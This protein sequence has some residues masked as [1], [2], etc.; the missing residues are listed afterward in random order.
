VI[1]RLN[2]VPHAE[3]RLLHQILGYTRVF[4]DAEDEGVRQS[5]V[6]VVEIADRVRVAAFEAL[7]ELAF[8]SRR[9]DGREKEREQEHVRVYD[10]ERG[11]GFIHVLPKAIN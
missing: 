6:P 2:P 4:D 10:A 11:A 5:P 7:G 3:K 9:L 1:E 8:F